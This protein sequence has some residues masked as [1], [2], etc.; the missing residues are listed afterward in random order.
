MLK[1]I[2]F[3]VDGVIA[4]T[5]SIHYKA[6][7]RVFYPYNINMPPDY[8]RSL[9]GY[10]VRDNIIKIKKDF[11]ID[12]DIERYIKLRNDEYASLL[13]RAVLE[14]NPGLQEILIWAK[15]QDIPMGICSSSKKNLAE[16]VLCSVFE[17]MGIEEP[18]YNFFDVIVTGDDG[19]R[20]KP[21]PDLYIETVKRMG[22][23]TFECMAIEDTQCGI[24]SAVSAGLKTVGLLTPFNLMGD[25]TEADKI[26]SSLGEIM[27]DNFWGWFNT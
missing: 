21:Y 5:E 10:S 26:V 17:H 6:F 22:K 7:Q 25:L 14:P 8:H 18:V 11:R 4:E 2:V 16:K 20:R 27:R 24:A 19:G 9:V 15:E 12:V 23:E 3:D 13:D 1:A